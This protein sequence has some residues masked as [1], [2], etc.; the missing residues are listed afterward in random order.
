ME[1]NGTRRPSCCERVR[2]LLS[3]V[4][5]LMSWLAKANPSFREPRLPELPDPNDSAAD[6]LVC[7]SANSEIVAVVREKLRTT[8]KRGHYKNL[9]VTASTEI[10]ENKVT[11]KIRDIL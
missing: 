1:T 5:S 4:M 2:T 7:K 3:A 8:R 9:G 11:P 6:G 10:T